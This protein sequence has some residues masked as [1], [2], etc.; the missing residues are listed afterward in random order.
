MKASGW[1]IKGDIFFLLLVLDC[2]SDIDCGTASAK[3]ANR[4]ANG[5]LQNDPYNYPQN[6]QKYHNPCHCSIR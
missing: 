3:P 1:L 2:F 5:Q 6:E 4:H